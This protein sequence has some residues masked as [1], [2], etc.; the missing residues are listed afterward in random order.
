MKILLG[1]L[2]ALAL[3]AT[4]CQRANNQPADLMSGP[5]PDTEVSS[6]PPQEVKQF[7]SQTY[8][9]GVPYEQASKYDSRQVPELLAMLGNPQ[10]EANW[11]NVVVVLGIIGDP[12]TVEPL[13]AF[14]GKG[15][16]TLSHPQYIAKSS[17][18]MALGYLINKSKDQKAF[19]FL[20]ESL[21]PNVWQKRGLGWT[22]PYQ[23]KMEERNLQLTKMAILGLALS[24]T[25]Q[26]ADA[27]RSLQ[28]NPPAE[29]A[30]GDRNQLKEL[31]TEALREHAMIAEKGLINYYRE[32]KR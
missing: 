3:T 16:G 14:A 12:Q 21:N 5:N 24:G 15:E 19:A 27:L 26:A 1:I 4:A 23:A 32:R 2:F 7:V 28:Q 13:I 31:A 20:T 11:P 22:S 6:E 10:E 30:E 18:L 9:H 25:P 8:I 17:V 29:I